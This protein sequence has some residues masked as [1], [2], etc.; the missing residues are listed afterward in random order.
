MEHFL[1]DFKV[2]L[3]RAYLIDYDEDVKYTNTKSQRFL[4]REKD[5]KKKMKTQ[6]EQMSEWKDKKIDKLIYSEDIDDFVL[7]SNFFNWCKKFTK[8]SVDG[9]AFGLKIEKAELQNIVDL[10]GNKQ[11]SAQ[12]MA[13]AKMMKNNDVQS[14]GFKTSN[15]L[16]EV[17]KQRQAKIL[18]KGLDGEQD[19]PAG[20]IGENQ[21]EPAKNL[22]GD[23]VPIEISED[24]IQRD[25]LISQ[26]EAE[27]EAGEAEK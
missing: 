8:F 10:E 14:F 26:I 11:P 23:D 13:L 3:T 12:E 5:S 20:E 27:D 17:I 25:V 9:S 19:E 1:K 15:N 18:E 21:P 16:G 22:F 24:N 2:S 7:V 4:T 6:V